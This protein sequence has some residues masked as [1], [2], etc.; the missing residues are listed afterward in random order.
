MTKGSIRELARIF[1][2]EDEAAFNLWT[3][4]PSHRR[5]QRC[6]GDYADAHR[7]TL[8][9]ILCEARLLIAFNCKV[10]TD[11]LEDELGTECPCGE[12]HPWE[13][14]DAERALWTLT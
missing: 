13:S 11:M 2:A 3:Y 14:S 6:H 5:A 4:L 8:T 12:D 9:E 7:P 1:D 10:T